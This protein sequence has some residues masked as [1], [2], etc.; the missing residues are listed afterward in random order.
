[1]SPYD[2]PAV[3][4]GEIAEYL[5]SS[6]LQTMKVTF[7]RLA[8]G[9]GQFLIRAIE[10]RNTRLAPYPSLGQVQVVRQ[11]DIEPNYLTIEVEGPSALLSPTSLVGLGFEAHELLLKH[12]I[13][14]K[15]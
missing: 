11:E 14:Q 9:V 6:N 10:A 2:D 7:E 15:C 1:M 8:I 5:Y 12:V 3:S 4:A 13:N